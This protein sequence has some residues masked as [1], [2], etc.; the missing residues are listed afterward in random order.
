MHILDTFPRDE[1]FQ[2]SIAD[3][4]RTTLGVLNLQDR[5]RVRF[6]LRRDTFRRFFSCLVYVPREKYSTLVR[7]R[8][9]AVLQDAFDG[10]AVDS[11]VQIFDSPLARVHIIVRTAPGERPRIS[12]QDIEERIAEIVVSWTDKIHRELIE[13][14]GRGDGDK[15]YRLYGNVFPAGYQED[16]TP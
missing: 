15:L 6:F 11:S 3:L 8:M 13:S 12:I 10:H 14:F 2:G 16:A 1:L 9:E 7:R 5:Q 4:T